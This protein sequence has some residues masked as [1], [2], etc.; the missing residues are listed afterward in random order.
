[1]TSS[2]TMNTLL[3]QQSGGVLSITLNRPEVRNAMSMAMVNE[4]IQTLA[5][6]E[7]DTGVR[8]VVL[9]GAG[10]HFCAGGDLQDM[11][12][13][14]MALPQPGVDAAAEV[15]AQF[16]RLCLAYARSSLPIITVLEGTVM[17]GGFGLACVSDV[18]LALGNAVF[19]LPETSLG[20]IPAQIA[21]FL[22]ER[23]GYAEAKR[24]SV[25][26]GKVEAA[27]ALA[28]RLVHE[29]HGDAASLDA[30]LR[31]VIDRI[32]G[33]APSA[34]AA[35]KVLLARTRFEPPQDLIQDAAAMFS[36]AVQGPEGVE[37]TTAFI[38]KRKPSWVPQAS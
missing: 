4:L 7:R 1:M 37:G 32:M 19:R 13:A 38:H 28:I 34:I 16:G 29:V 11:A 6:A 30:A 31:Q 10:G 22:V 25:T 14:R 8:V 12:K 3:L 33:C 20:V 24:L 17:G 5:Q 18:T 36:R 9:R 26:G 23:I 35:T 15:N 27:E 21:P 2:S